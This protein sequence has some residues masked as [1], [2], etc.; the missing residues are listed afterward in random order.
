[1]SQASCL[2]AE[3]YQMIRPLKTAHLT[4]CWGLMYHFGF[5]TFSSLFRDVIWRALGTGVVAGE[6][7]WE[8]FGV[9]R[10]SITMVD[11]LPAVYI[12]Y[13]TGTK[14]PTVDSVLG[15]AVQHY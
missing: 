5:H 6:V 3:G 11:C 12:G 15:L 4:K 14:F 2:D 1:M 13:A 8:E 9:R 7:C 10:S